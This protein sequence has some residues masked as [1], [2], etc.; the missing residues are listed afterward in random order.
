MLTHGKAE[1]LAEGQG[2]R[3]REKEGGDGWLVVLG[4]GLQGTKK[5]VLC[6]FHSLFMAW[7]RTG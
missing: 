3:E 4:E 2:E 1:G 6:A 5:R 7:K